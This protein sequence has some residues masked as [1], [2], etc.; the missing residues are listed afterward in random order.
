MEGCGLRTE[1]SLTRRNMCFPMCLMFKLVIEAVYESALL[2]VETA[3]LQHPARHVYIARRWPD[4]VRCA[5]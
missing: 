4:D 3:Q 5:G 2:S 1:T